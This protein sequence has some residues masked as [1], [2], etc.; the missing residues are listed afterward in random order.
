MTLAKGVCIIEIKTQPIKLWK[1]ILKS[2]YEISLEVETAKKVFLI[3][4]NVLDCLAWGDSRMAKY[5]GGGQGWREMEKH[6]FPYIIS[7]AL[8]MQMNMFLE[9]LIP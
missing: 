7:S 4:S 3:H 2:T 6:M 5:Q 9:R 8:A 1:G